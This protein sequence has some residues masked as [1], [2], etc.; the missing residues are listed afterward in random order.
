[1]LGTCLKCHQEPIKF[2]CSFLNETN[3]GNAQWVTQ[4]KNQCV[5]TSIFPLFPS[6]TL[7][8]FW[9][10][11]PEI[12]NFWHL[13]SNYL[14]LFFFSTISL[15]THANKI[16]EN[17]LFLNRKCSFQSVQRVG[18]QIW[19]SNILNIAFISFLILEWLAF[20]P[21]WNELWTMC[22]PRTP[23]FNDGFSSALCL[24]SSK[25]QKFEIQVKTLS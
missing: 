16:K 4:I 11:L 20:S 14:W 18:L 23:I 5:I 21:Y 7:L 22:K 17:N 19:A 24:F 13:W 12:K 9:K 6:P 15:S 8:W 1:M 3:L 25:I 2:F 10:W